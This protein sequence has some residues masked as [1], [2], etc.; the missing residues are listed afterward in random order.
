MMLFSGHGLS[1]SA[2]ARLFTAGFPPILDRQG[3]APEVVDPTDT[4]TFIHA[5]EEMDKFQANEIYMQFLAFSRW[6]NILCKLF[7]LVRD[8][9]MAMVVGWAVALNLGQGFCHGNGG[10]VGCGID[11]N[12]LLSGPLSASDVSHCNC[13]NKIEISPLLMNEFINCYGNKLKHF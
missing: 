5:K 12:V 7:I 10:G 4:S 3:E 1:R 9:V 8:F 6:E 13:Q 11:N 2:Y